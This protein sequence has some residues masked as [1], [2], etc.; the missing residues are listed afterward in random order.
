MPFHHVA[1]AT[2]DLAATHR[3]YTEL[4]GFEL[5]K[6]VT[7]PTEHVDGW[8]K[9]VFYDTGGDYLA[10][11]ELHDDEQPDFPTDISTGVGLPAWVNHLAFRAELADL[12]GLRR[13]WQD[14]GIDVAEI[15]HGF[16][17]SIY[18]TDPNGILVEWCADVRPLDDDDRRQAE[19][20]LHNPR[21]DLDPAPEP[22]FHLAN[23]V[24]S[25]A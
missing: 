6:V 22:R 23:Q 7:G 8:A 3:F 11:W 5:V 2:K 15:D 21:P 9:H 17:V 19:Q 13:R 14:A 16:C 12:E 18:A 25:P 4:M 20:R 1:L 24:Q 10:F